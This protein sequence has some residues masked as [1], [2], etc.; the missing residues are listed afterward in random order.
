M[1][2]SGHLAANLVRT[3]LARPCTYTASGG[4]S[5]FPWGFSPALARIGSEAGLHPHPLRAGPRPPQR[6]PLHRGVTDRPLTQCVSRPRS[7]LPRSKFGADFDALAALGPGDTLVVWNMD[8]AFRDLLHAL[9]ILEHLLARGANFHSLTDA[10][11]TGTPFGRFA[12][13]LINASASSSAH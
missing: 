3:K 9:R 11:D 13:Q 10:I 1:K 4:G 12:Y 5:A 8:R 7:A 6:P 2:R